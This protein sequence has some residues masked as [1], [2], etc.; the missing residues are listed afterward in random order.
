MDNKAVDNIS[1]RE[2]AQ[3]LWILL[4]EIDTMSDIY[5]P[6]I[7]DVKSLMLFYN[8]VMRCVNKRHK[9]MQSNGYNVY[10]Y[11]EFKEAIKSGSNPFDIF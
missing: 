3:E 11:K 9:Y 1:D 4:D 7:N 2:I 6:T 8:N 10:T 5:K